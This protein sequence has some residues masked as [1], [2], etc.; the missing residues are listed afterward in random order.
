[1]GYHD[2]VINAKS[3]GD[4]NLGCIRTWILNK[5]FISGKNPASSFAR[6]NPHHL[7]EA[8]ITLLRMIRTV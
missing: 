7:L 2:T 8:F 1:M 5:P 6:H 4:V 3:A